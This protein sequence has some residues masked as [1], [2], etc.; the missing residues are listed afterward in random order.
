MNH[1]ASIIIRCCNEEQHIGQ[2]LRGIMQQ[3]IREVEVIIVDSGS[4]DA[5]LSIASR[6]PAKLISIR[7]EE[8]SFGRS[9]NAGCSSASGE[10]IVAVSAH[11]YPV[12]E[13]WLDHLLAPFSDPQMAL[14]YGRQRGNE[15][16]KYSEHQVFAKWFPTESNMSQP[17]PFCNNA[18]AA[19]RR[20]LWDQL[21]YNESLTGLEDIEWAKRAL[22]L[23]Y[24][25]AYAAN[26]EI[27]H[28][29]DENAR[30]IYNRYRREAIALKSILPEERFSLWDLVY[31]F[32]SNVISDYYYVRRDGLL[33][34]NLSGI[35]IFRWM[36]FWGTYRGFRWRGPIT[37]QLREKFYY[38]NGLARSR[39][40]WQGPVGGR[41]MID[42]DVTK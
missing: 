38:P 29:H 30:Q 22:Q 31:L 20:S 19:I 18:N 16:T 5:T 15:K 14:V 10:F 21:P 41:E 40:K 37:T 6:Y 27:I 39:A 26:A 13:D 28:V 17:H 4:T 23:G 34:A 42:Y 35:P 11:V 1:R 7:P 9:L 8:F 33:R 36:Q 12:Y 32:L 3:T 2:L 25:V 24:K